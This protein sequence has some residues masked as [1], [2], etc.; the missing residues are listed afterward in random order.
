MD[1]LNRMVLQW[2]KGGE[3]HLRIKGKTTIVNAVLLITILGVYFLSSSRF[4]NAGLNRLMGRPQRTGNTAAILVHVDRLEGVADLSHAL[5]QNGL[6]A[7]FFFR[8]ETC[9]N[10]I[11]LNQV[12]DDGH[13]IAIAGNA[14]DETVAD[15]IDECI[16]AFNE[17]GIPWSRVFMPIDGYNNT[18]ASYVGKKGFELV[19]WSVNSL[20]ADAAQP[21]DIIET[22]A[23]NM[24][25]ETFLL[26]TPQNNT[27][28][29]VTRL[30][31]L[32]DEQSITT[33]IVS[34]AY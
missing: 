19:L 17:A 24:T 6:K 7:T 21:E 32:L 20:D 5:S 13:E 31:R 14:L 30:S 15:Q 11:I 1:G 33:S 10:H 2:A 25:P 18:G 22:V 9:G 8:A 27:I 16:S 23:R 4:I 29:A 26:I 12:Y 28:K 34:K 3:Y